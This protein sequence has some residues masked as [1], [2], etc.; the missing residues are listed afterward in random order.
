MAGRAAIFVVG[1]GLQRWDRRYAWSLASW[2]PG[3]GT[4]DTWMF[5][6]IGVSQNGWFIMETP[7]KMDDLGVPLF[8]ETPKYL[9]HSNFLGLVGGLY[10]NFTCLFPMRGFS[11][12]SV[13]LGVIFSPLH[14][15][16]NTRG[17]DKTII[18]RVATCIG[19]WQFQALFST[20]CF[21]AKRKGPSALPELTFAW[22]WS[23]SY[24]T[25]V[26][27]TAQCWTSLKT[28]NMNILISYTNTDSNCNLINKKGLCSSEPILFPKG[29]QRMYW[30]QAA[31]HDVIHQISCVATKPREHRVL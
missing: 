14:W 1:L 15:R 24:V 5:P 3:L 19:S 28:I 11:I 27:T 18:L 13:F 30:T 6:K 17:K 25:T 12:L 2:Y 9:N 4:N 23:L 26:T 7:I 29:S 21:Q 8:L 10:F 16:W 22:L 31:V 20:K